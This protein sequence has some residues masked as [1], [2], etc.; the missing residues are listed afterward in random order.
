VGASSPVSS[1]EVQSTITDRGAI[2]VVTYEAEPRLARSFVHTGDCINSVAWPE[3]RVRTT[4]HS[5]SSPCKRT[6]VSYVCQPRECSQHARSQFASLHAARVNG[7]VARTSLASAGEPQTS[8]LQAKNMIMW[9]SDSVCR[10]QMSSA[11]SM[12]SKL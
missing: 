1:A 9:K 12:S 5:I 3:S 4:R 6:L 11:T 8:G 7:F 10:R 2:I